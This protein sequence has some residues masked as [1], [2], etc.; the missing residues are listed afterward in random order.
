MLLQ[1]AEGFGDTAATLQKIDACPGSG[2][3]LRKFHGREGGVEVKHGDG[4]EAAA[5]DRGFVVA[6]EAGILP[7]PFIEI[8]DAIFG[9]EGF[10]NN[11][12]E[13]VKER[14]PL[15]ARGNHRHFVSFPLKIRHKYN[16]DGRRGTISLI[17]RRKKEVEGSGAQVGAAAA[18]IENKDAKS[19][20]C[21]CGTKNFEE[22][23]EFV[24]FLGGRK[25]RKHCCEGAGKEADRTEKNGDGAAT[26]NAE[27][28]RGDRLALET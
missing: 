17:N 19:D 3:G 24:G 11:A 7:I 10:G 5:I 15:G 13:P 26:G 16:W 2:L 6:A 20:Q 8:E 4:A 1:A 12:T 28:I 27:N 18:E 14:G 22:V 23:E 21:S 25:Q 9:A